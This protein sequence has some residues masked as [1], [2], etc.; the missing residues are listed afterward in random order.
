MSI[1]I[2]TIAFGLII[3][4]AIGLNESMCPEDSKGESTFDAPD[5]GIYGTISREEASYRELTIPRYPERAIQSDVTGTVFVHVWIR[6]DH[7]VNNAEIEAL[8]PPSAA[9]LQEGLVDVIRSWQFNPVRIHGEPVVSE[10]I[11][12]VRFRFEN[13]AAPEST[14]RPKLGVVPYLDTIEVVGERG[15]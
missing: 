14:Y 2:A 10:V 15:K 8:D 13:Q 6:K 3:Q 7:G 4:S 1:G 12:P 5:T 9:L 11:V